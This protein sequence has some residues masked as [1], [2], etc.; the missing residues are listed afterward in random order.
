MKEKCLV[1]GFGVPNFVSFV[2]FYISF[3]GNQAGVF[4]LIIFLYI[5]RDQ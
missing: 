2:V 1:M 3:L 5:D 4:Y